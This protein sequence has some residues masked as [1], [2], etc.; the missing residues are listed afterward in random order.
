MS[1]CVQAMVE[2]GVHEEPGMVSSAGSLEPRVVELIVEAQG[3]Q[4]EVG[5][6]GVAG[7]LAVDRSTTKHQ[8]VTD[9]CIHR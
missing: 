3:D 9:N 1:T 6:G 4:R 5:D 7:S 2:A 8:E